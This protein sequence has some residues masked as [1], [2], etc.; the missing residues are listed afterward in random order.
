MYMLLAEYKL[1]LMTKMCKS[2]SDL[3]TGAEGVKH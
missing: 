1:H 2:V 3:T